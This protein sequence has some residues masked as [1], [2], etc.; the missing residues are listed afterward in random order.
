[1]KDIIKAMFMGY[2]FYHIFS[3]LYQK[4]YF[5]IVFRIKILPDCFVKTKNSFILYK[6]WRIYEKNGA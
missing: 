4:L 1:M 5:Y 3:K 6:R 2:P